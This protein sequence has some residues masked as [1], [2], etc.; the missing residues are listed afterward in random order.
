MP[1]LL[2]TKIRQRCFLSHVQ[3][4]SVKSRTGVR[5]LLTLR[6]CWSIGLDIGDYMHGTPDVTSKVE[7]KKGLGDGCNFEFRE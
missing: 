6:T 3:D 5:R 4:V 7:E 1:F 2:S